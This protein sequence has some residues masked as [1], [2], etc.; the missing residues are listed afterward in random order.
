MSNTRSQRRSFLTQLGAGMTVAG[1][2]FAT[3]DSPA[4]AQ[5]TGMPFHPARHAEDAWMDALPG[6]HRLVIDSTTPTGFGEA[7]AFAGNFLTANVNGYKLTDHDSAVIIV[8][9][10]FSTPFAYKD[11]VWARYARVIPPVATLKDPKTGQ[12]PA[13]NLLDATG[14]GMD[15]PNF[16]TTIDALVGRGVQFAVCQMATQFFA[17]LIAGQAGNKQAVYDELAGS[18]VGNSH[19]VAAGVVGVNRAQE[20]G[21]TLVSAG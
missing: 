12:V 15:L 14:Y 2:A 13:F 8:A 3:G 18:L 21:Y 17:G 16:G 7:L 1:A 6:S 4:A 19:M 5:A 9:R 20:Y 11:S 10:H